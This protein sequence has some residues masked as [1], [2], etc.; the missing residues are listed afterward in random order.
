MGA[1]IP[2][3]RTRSRTS[4]RTNTTPRPLNRQQNITNEVPVAAPDRTRDSSIRC[5]RAAQ[6]S[7]AAAV[8]AVC[9]PHNDD[10]LPSGFNPAQCPLFEPIDIFHSAAARATRPT[11]YRS[12]FML[13]PPQPERCGARHGVKVETFEQL[14]TLWL[15]LWSQGA[16]FMRAIGIREFRDQASSILAG[17]ET[18]VI[19]R[20][21]VPI[22]FFVPITAKDRRA[23]RDALGRLA[24]LVDDVIARSGL[25]EDEIVREISPKRRTR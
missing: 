5:S 2:R 4:G 24:G 13:R 8:A 6:F 20:H 18:L 15:H 1:R 12:T 3:H 9:A 14:P 10:S 23:G 17:G 21:G 7:P 11:A 19:E 25:D 16:W 22:G